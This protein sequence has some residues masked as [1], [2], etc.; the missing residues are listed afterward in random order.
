MP[1]RPDFAPNA[2]VYDEAYYAAMYRPH[3]LLRSARKYRERDEALLRAVRPRPGL[4]LLEVGSARGDT[5]FFFAPL[6]AEVVGIDAA[7]TAVEVARS[8]ATARNL[9]NVRFETADARDL[10]LFESGSFDAVL[11]ADFVEH[12][13]DEVLRPCLA[14]ALRVLRPGGALGVYTPN[15]DHWAERIKAA[16]PGLQQPD[17]I[18][19][20]PAAEVVRLV[21][22]A[23][24]LLDDLSFSAS[25][26]PLLGGID[27]LFPRAGLCRFRTVLRALRPS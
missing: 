15:R 27:R 4:Q 26:Y 17:H 13:T 9:V 3:W 5:A 1:P 2:E 10:A 11:L 8:A 21:A 7:G 25:P 24:F 14:E 23:G 22:S 12:V 16:V 20:R 6:V 18:A 19:V